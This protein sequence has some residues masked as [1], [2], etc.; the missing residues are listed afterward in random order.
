R[1]I[2][3]NRLAEDGNRAFAWCELA[4]DELHERRLAGAVRPE[5]T[6]D[7]GRHLQRHVIQANDLA[8][9]LREVIRRDDAHATTSTP[10][11]RFSRISPDTTTSATTTRN[12]TGTDILNRSGRRKIASPICARSDATDIHAR[13]ESRV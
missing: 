4:G 7:A 2:P 8:V 1:R 10:R 11:T 5:K 12:A 3:P 6:G 13:R 9:P